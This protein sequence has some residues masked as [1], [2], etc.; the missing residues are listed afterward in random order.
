MPFDGDLCR[1]LLMSISV[2]VGSAD[3]YSESRTVEMLDNLYNHGI[4]NAKQYLSRL[5]RGT[6]PQL[7]A[8]LREMA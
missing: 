8:L 3:S 7:E 2:D 4:I 6:V 1:G 5:P